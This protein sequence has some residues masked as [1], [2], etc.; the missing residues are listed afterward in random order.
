VCHR[1]F[2][3]TVDFDPG[4][5]TAIL[6]SPGIYDQDAFIAKYD[7]NGNYIWAGKLGG[8]GITNGTALVVDGSGNIYVASSFEETVDFDPGPGTAK[9]TSMGM[10]DIYVVKLGCGD[11][12]FSYLTLTECEAYHFDGNVYT[13]D[14]TYTHHFHN[15]YG[16]DST[17]TLDLTFYEIAPA[18]TVDGFVLGVADTYNTYQWIKNSTDIPGATH[19]TYTV[20]ENADY[21]VKV[22]NEQGCEGTSDIYPVTNYNVHINDAIQLKKQIR[23]YPNPTADVLHINSSVTIMTILTTIDGRMIIQAEN[24]KTIAM[25][26]LADGIYLLRI[27]DKEGH[28]IKTEKIVK[29]D[30]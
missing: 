9:L 29:Q 4:P 13:S 8:D 2:R 19:P 14:G 18:I 27:A 15:I 12:T 16:C 6:V 1:A 5:G 21:Q 24:P 23:V 30:R 17:V 22:T 20:T 11:T 28:W 7:P 10:Q 3:G 25:E 26:N